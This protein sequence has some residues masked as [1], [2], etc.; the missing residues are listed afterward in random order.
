VDQQLKGK[1]SAANRVFYRKNLFLLISL[2]TGHTLMH[3]FQQGWYIILPSVKETFG[4]TNVQYGGIESIRSVSSTAVQLPSGAVSDILRKQWVI[5]VASALLGVGFAYMVLGLAGNYAAVLFAAVLIGISIALW[6][7]P[8]LSVLSA[9]LAERRGMALSIHGMGGNLGN[10]VGPAVIG[11][12]IGT[13]AWQT[14]SWVM[15]MPM[16][17]FAILLWRLL[18]GVPGR[19]GAGVTGKNYLSTL[20]RQLKNRIIMGLIISGG[21]RSMGTVSLFAFFS[22]YCREDLGFGP[23]KSG[24]YYTTMMASGIASQPLLGYLSDRFGRK[25]VLVPSLVLMSLLEVILVWSGAGFGLILVALGIGL[26]IY[27]L[28]AILQAALMD[29]APEEAGATTIAFLFGSQALFTIPSPTIA[30]WLSD[31]Y[32]TPSVF[33]YS[34][35][36]VFLSALLLVLL[37]MDRS[38]AGR[39]IGSD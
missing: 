38:R 16:I 12:I 1:T 21:I 8:A 11:M 33:F 6:H 7:P 17:V 37:P 14:A 15:A 36:L 30:G 23:M 10:S 3:C 25:I 4:L 24:F 34:G 28:G 19:E 35:G 20:L 22:L 9:R 13:F 29:E 5:I 27:A 26:F 32:G 31:T 2:A 18:S 39:D